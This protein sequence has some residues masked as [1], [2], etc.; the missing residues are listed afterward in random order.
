MVGEKKV[1]VLS[2]A[3]EP[4]CKP[5]QTFKEPD[6]DRTTLAV[7]VGVAFSQYAPGRIDELV[8]GLSSSQEKVSGE[9]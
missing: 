9:A 1:G 7:R 2:P 4:H 8:P 3:F 5:T 6:G